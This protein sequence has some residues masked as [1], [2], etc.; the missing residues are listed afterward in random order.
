MG[1]YSFYDVVNHLPRRYDD[2]S[3]TRERDLEDKER[4]TI[5]AKIISNISVTK[6]FHRVPLAAFDVLTESNTYFHVV[7]FNRSYLGKN[8]SLND[9]V[10]IIGSFDKKKN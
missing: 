5:Y 9:W 4:V 10:T 8:F 7:A 6:S 3:L 1:I 2:Y